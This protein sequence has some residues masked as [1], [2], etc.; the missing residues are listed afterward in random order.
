MLRV[1]TN[2]IVATGGTTPLNELLYKCLYC[3]VRE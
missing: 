2:Q 1:T 3:I